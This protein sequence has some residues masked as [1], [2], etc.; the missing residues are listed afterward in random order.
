MIVIVMGVTGTGKT[1]IGTLLASREG[2][3]YA[4]GDD[5]GCAGHFGGGNSG[6]NGCADSEAASA[7][8]VFLPSFRAERVRVDNSFFVL[9]QW[10]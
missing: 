10:T 6:G 8:S 7:V 5:Y 1:T 3:H 9:V 4:E 2:W